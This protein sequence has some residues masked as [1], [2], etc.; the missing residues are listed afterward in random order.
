MSFIRRFYIYQKERFPFAAHGLLIAAFTFSAVSYSRMCRGVEGFIPGDIYGWGILMTITLFFLLRISDEFKDHED[1]VKYRK[2]L[3]VPRGL[4]SLRE[5][6]RVA[7]VVVLIQ[8]FVLAFF[9]PETIMLFLPV[10]VYLL[11]MRYEFGAPEWLKKRPVLYMISHMFIIPLIDIYASGLDWLLEGASAPKGLFFFFAVSYMNGIVMEIGRKIK[12]KEMEE[13]GVVSYTSLW[14]IKKA[15]MIWMGI[16]VL[17]FSIAILA[18]WY[19]GYML[20]ILSILSFVLLICITPAIL[21]ILNPGKKKSK[22][23][24]IASAFWTLMMY[25][26]LGALPMISSLSE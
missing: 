15:P 13:E 2:Y 17:N 23:I 22:T 20:L 16:L 26:T 7:L 12:T 9:L 19:T 3:P 4:I 21:F 1:D 6:G 14:G 10:V 25:F 18:G 11:M 24:E 5:L 8:I